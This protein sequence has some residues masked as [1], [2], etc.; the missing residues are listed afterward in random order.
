MIICPQMESANKGPGRTDACTVNT[1]EVSDLPSIPVH[2]EAPTVSETSDDPI[3]LE[4]DRLIEKMQ[5][6][7]AMVGVD[8]VF[9][10]SHRTLLGK[11]A[12]QKSDDI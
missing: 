12:L 11:S 8:A 5:R 7:D 9:R 1:G 3:S 4:F 10:R 2:R 6:P